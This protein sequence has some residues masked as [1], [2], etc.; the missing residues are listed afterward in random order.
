MSQLEAA[1]VVLR[2]RLQAAPLSWDLPTRA[3]GVRTRDRIVQQVD[4]YLL[5][6]LA[7]IDAPLLAVVGGST[8]AGK[9]T[10]V[11]SLVGQEVSPAG[12]L[13]PT[14]RAPVLVCHPSDRGAFELSG[15]GGPDVLPD[16]PR[17]SGHADGAT[18]LRLVDA[19]ALRP[20]LA[21]ID[22][23][24]IDSVEVAHHELAA[25]L[26]GAADLWLFVTTAA[27]YADAVPWAHLA[28]AH[29]R[30]VALAVVVNRVPPE[31]MD[32]V[33]ADLQAMLDAQGLG[34]TR[35]F[36]V[37][38]QALAEGR[39]G[40][41]LDAL[42]GWLD[43]L[44]G[45]E[46]AR[47]DVVRRS[48]QGALDSL[49]ARAERVADAVAAQAAA[50]RHLRDAAARAFDDARARIEQELA[51]GAVLRDEVLER[52]KE[53]IGTTA[54]MD[55]L[56]RS[57]GRVRDR[58]RAAATGTDP[59]ARQA[60]GA[61]E[62]NLVSLV[63]HA[64]DEAALATVDAWRTMEGGPSVLAAAPPTLDRSSVDLPASATRQVEQWQAGVLQLVRD[65][66]G[67]RMKL[68]RGLSFGVNSIGVALMVVVFASTGGLTGG[69]VVV[70]GGTAAVSQALLSAIFGEQAVRDLARAAHQ[71][72]FMRID[73][74]LGEQRSRVQAALIGGAGPDDAQQIRVAA[75]RVAEARP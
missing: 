31:A 3:A 53:H 45:D 46:Q 23:P 61:I 40:A 8:G 33:P 14:T 29:E 25:Q 63:V 56:Q 65:T 9:S 22:A 16:M 7:R 21:L 42:R 18:G 24:D 75:A 32:A 73:V 50:N 11:N 59:P 4:D 54:W 37:P 47:R 39:I 10:I 6:R 15:A 27:R 55:R 2:D 66:A 12:V 13:R 35:L 72:L 41:P 38:E 51:S 69:E 34:D 58:V 19:P 60:Q 5:P 43:D 70:A 1:L 67:T 57:V 28:D 44:A 17:V 74:L 48:L 30:S 71:D 20:G 64:A 26:L 36:V 52:F 49:P 62:H 68:A